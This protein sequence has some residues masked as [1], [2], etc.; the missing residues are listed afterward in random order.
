MITGKVNLKQRNERVK[1]FQN[2]ELKILLINIDAGK[3]AL[4]LDRADTTIFTD[5]FPPAGDIQQ[6]EDRFVATKPEN[7]VYN[8]KIVQLMMKDSYDEHIFQKVQ[9]GA[10]MIDIVN[11]YKKYLKG[12]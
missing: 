11:D 2:E 9:D 12:E 3:E 7:V 10:E 1:A 8:H 6:A 5:V 4:T